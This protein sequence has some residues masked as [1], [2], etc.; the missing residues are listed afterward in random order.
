MFT[1]NISDKVYFMRGRLL[2]SLISQ[3]ALICHNVGLY[4]VYVSQALSC[5]TTSHSLDN[6]CCFDVHR[7]IIHI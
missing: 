4:E 3:V 5:G 6:L 7:S 1:S 2:I